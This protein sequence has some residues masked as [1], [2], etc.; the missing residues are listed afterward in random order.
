MVEPVDE[1]GRKYERAFQLRKAGKVREAIEILTSLSDGGYAPAQ[2]F[3][4]WL[5]ERGEGRAADR[6]R[7]RFWYEAAAKAGNSVGQLYLGILDLHEGRDKEGA[8]WIQR[9]AAQGYAP[10]LYRLGVS[11]WRGLGV[12]L[13]KDEAYRCWER[14]AALGHPYAQRQIALGLIKGRGGIGGVARGLYWFLRI[15]LLATKFV[16]KDP[17]SEMLHP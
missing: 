12:T 14:A 7:A 8:A 3:L 17:D 16:M 4:G 9:A 6:Q 2:A 1:P 13:S 15:P 10:A 11:Y 5:C